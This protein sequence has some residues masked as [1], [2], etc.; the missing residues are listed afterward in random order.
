MQTENENMK[1]RRASRVLPILE[2][3]C[4]IHEIYENDE[5]V[6]FK[7]ISLQRHMVHLSTE[8][9]QKIRCKKYLNTFIYITKIALL[10]TAYED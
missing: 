9:C 10:L 5:G 2:F 1:T 6:G 8:M 4:R 7:I 3:L